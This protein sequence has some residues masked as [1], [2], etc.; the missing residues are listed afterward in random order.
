M[1][2][3][4]AYTWPPAWARELVPAAADVDGWRRDIARTLTGEDR[5]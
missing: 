2:A 5:G 1:N 4:E 3:P